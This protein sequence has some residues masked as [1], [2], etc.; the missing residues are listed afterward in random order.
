MNILQEL[1]NKLYMK[2]NLLQSIGIYEKWPQGR[3]KAFFHKYSLILDNILSSWS[4]W[5][6]DTYYMDE[7]GWL[8]YLWFELHGIEKIVALLAIWK[9][10]KTQMA[11]M[12]HEKQLNLHQ[13]V[14]KD[15]ETVAL[16]NERF[17]LRWIQKI[18]S[19]HAWWNH[20]LPLAWAMKEITNTDFSDDKEWRIVLV[21]IVMLYLHLQGFPV[22][23][24]FDDFPTNEWDDAILDLMNNFDPD[25]FILKAK[26]AWYEDLVN[27][28]KENCIYGTTEDL[29]DH[30]SWLARDWINP[31][32][33]HQSAVD[34]KRLIGKVSV[35]S[36]ITQI[37]ISWLQDW[38]L[39]TQS[40]PSALNHPQDP[41]FP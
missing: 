11:T 24:I 22:W 41:L 35:E 29:L 23:L 32:K 1:T 9:H 4:L 3:I 5:M 39:F 19:S 16:Y 33:N 28:V 12:R 27:E 14:R 20:F 7:N 36:K 6:Q 10:K 25:A 21:W 18:P 15:I 38:V 40:P 26:E 31:P 37:F 17:S 8:F 13:V 30:I 34:M 2:E